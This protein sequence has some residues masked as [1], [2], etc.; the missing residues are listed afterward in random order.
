MIR[1]IEKIEMKTE[2]RRERENRIK[3]LNIKKKIKLQN[4]ELREI[5]NSMH[6]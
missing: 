3:K 6:D 2:E 5:G 1:A 4:G